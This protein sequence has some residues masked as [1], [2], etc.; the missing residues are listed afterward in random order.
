MDW[1]PGSW[2]CFEAR[3]Q[4]VY[5]QPAALDVASA[6]LS[7]RPA[8]VD[9]GAIDGL[10]SSLAEAQAGRAFILQGGDCAERLSDG[11]DDAQ[12]MSALLATLSDDVAAVDLPVITIG[13]IAG[14]FA[15]PRSRAFERRGGLTL[16]AWRGDSVNDMAFDREARKADPTRLLGAYEHAVR[17]LT[18]IPPPPRM[19]TSHEALLLPFEEALI[20]TDADGRAFAGSAHFLWIGVRTLFAGSAHVE[21]LRGLANPIGLKVGPDMR[22][23]DL[24]QILDDLNPDHCAGRISL[25]LRMGSRGIALRLPALL[26]AVTGTGHPVSWCCDPLH[27]NTL[28]ATAGKRRH[29]D[30]IEAETR[31][32]FVI[33]A[34]EGVH[35]AGL[36][37]EMTA[38]SVIECDER[39][40]DGGPADN[41]CRDPR[42]NAD[43]A[44]R[45][46]KVA[47]DALARR[48]ASRKLL[49][50]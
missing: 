44:R 11:P 21:L 15:K 48:T 34:S 3:Q 19:Y 22:P 10:I 7:R 36:H 46:T 28:T 2:R 41:E 25:I 12:A 24:I 45:I 23:S 13:R 38:R 1:N 47:A 42:L 39:N 8:L 20:R 29:M 14:Q 27:G 40:L 33:L 37:L 35:P 4:P 9:P 31:A 30:D 5:G 32:F 26:K 49:P 16:P 50:A 43:Q 17:T 18:A 6:D